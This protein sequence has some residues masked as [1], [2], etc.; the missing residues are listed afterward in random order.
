MGIQLTYAV[1]LNS[2]VL[3]PHNGSCVS[4]YSTLYGIGYGIGKMVV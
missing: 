4:V 2:H 1:E 3:P